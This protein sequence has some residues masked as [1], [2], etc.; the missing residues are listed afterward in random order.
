MKETQPPCHSHCPFYESTVKQYEIKKVETNPTTYM[1]LG[2]SISSEKVVEQFG[3]TVGIGL[4]GVV[5]FGF[6]IKEGG[7]LDDPVKAINDV[8]DKIDEENVKDLPAL[9]IDQLGDTFVLQ[10]GAQ[11]KLDFTF[12]PS[13]IE[14][15]G[16]LF[17]EIEP[18]NMGMVDLFMTTGMVEYNVPTDDDEMEE[19]TT[20][21]AGLYMF[22]GG[23][24]SKDFLLKMVD[25]VFG[26]LG[27]LLVR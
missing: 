13:Q 4:S 12:D 20:I 3:E 14:G 19:T 23:A 27:Q 10:Q 17:P 15:F 22:A 16:F 9:L 1:S 11:A 5:D 6:I 24:A 8:F 26:F 21:P 18:I 25:F 7:V 2:A